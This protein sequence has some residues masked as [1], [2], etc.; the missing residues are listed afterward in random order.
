MARERETYWDINNLNFDKEF[1][2]DIN[3]KLIHCTFFAYSCLENPKCFYFEKKYNED[4]LSKY[5]GIA[6]I[7]IHYFGSSNLCAIVLNFPSSKFS[8]CWHANIFSN[9]NGKVGL[10]VYEDFRIILPMD[11]RYRRDP[12][13]FIHRRSDAINIF[14]SSDCRMPTVLTNLIFSYFF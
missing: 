8:K 3:S 5:V 1:I 6:N 2:D 13:K 7:A 11:Y 12:K 14:K 4:N 10:D 9:C